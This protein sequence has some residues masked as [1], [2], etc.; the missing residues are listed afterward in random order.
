VINLVS[1]TP[2]E[3]ELYYNRP[4]LRNLCDSVGQMIMDLHDEEFHL[5]IVLSLNDTDNED[6]FTLAFSGS[7]LA[8]DFYPDHIDVTDFRLADGEESDVLESFP[9]D[10]VNA[11]TV[12]LVNQIKS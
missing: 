2:I 11:A 7:T 12:W 4:D 5:D 9:R 8:L 10:N 6:E 1:A 3:H